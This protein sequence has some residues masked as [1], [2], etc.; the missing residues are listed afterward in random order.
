M[1]FE[2]EKWMKFPDGQYQFKASFM[3]YAD[4]ESMSNPVDEK[5]RENISQMKTERKGK[6]TY[7]E[8]L[9]TYVPSGWSVQ[10][11]FAYG[12]VFDPMRMYRGKDC[13]E[14]FVEHIEYEVKELYA[15]QH[16]HNNR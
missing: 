7:T 4:F 2:K 16:F 13:E 6:T 12:D 11:T 14:K 15:T 5:C 8:K 10:I 3:L 9:N 1:R